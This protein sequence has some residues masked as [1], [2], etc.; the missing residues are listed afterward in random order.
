MSSVQQAKFFRV[1]L[2][3]TGLQ[4]QTFVITGGWKRNFY[5]SYPQPFS[6]P[7]YTSLSLFM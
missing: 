7:C 5:R 4:K 1:L 3:T 2:V 6:M